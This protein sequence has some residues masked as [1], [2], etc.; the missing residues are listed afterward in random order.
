MIEIYWWPLG[1]TE[2]WSR[3]IF[4]A[5]LRQLGKPEG[6]GFDWPEASRWIPVLQIR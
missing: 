2:G 5:I 3:S 1:T 4:R 6:D